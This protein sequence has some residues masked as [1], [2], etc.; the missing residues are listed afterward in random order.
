[1]CF[2][3]HFY[4]GNLD[5]CEMTNVVFIEIQECMNSIKINKKN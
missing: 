1:M 4:K 5:F 2:Y 3:K